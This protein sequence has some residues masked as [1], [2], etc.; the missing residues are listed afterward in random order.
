[1]SY[2]KTGSSKFFVPNEK[3]VLGVRFSSDEGLIYSIQ[4]LN[5]SQSRGYIMSSRALISTVNDNSLDLLKIG[6]TNGDF[7]VVNYYNDGLYAGQIVFIITFKIT[8]NSLI[9]T[10]KFRSYQSLER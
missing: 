2:K 9:K 7:V 3:S 8:V 5:F 4:S 10:E 1:M 6:F